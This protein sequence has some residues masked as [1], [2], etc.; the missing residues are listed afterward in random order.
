MGHSLG[1]S[2]EAD[3]LSAYGD[4][5]IT[6]ELSNKGRLVSPSLSTSGSLSSMAIFNG[7]E[8]TLTDEEETTP[9]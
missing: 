2:Y 7:S 6:T 8:T 5:H 9:K 3:D 4:G 1:A